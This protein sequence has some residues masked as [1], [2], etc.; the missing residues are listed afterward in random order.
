MPKR[1]QGNIISDTPPTGLSGVWSLREAYDFT[2]AGDWATLPLTG[3]IAVIFS[4]SSASD[5]IQYQQMASSGDT[6][7]FGSLVPTGLNGSGNSSMSSSTYALQT[8][9][10][11]SANRTDV[12][13]V[14]ISTKGNTQDWGDLNRDS[15]L[16][17]CASN[18]TRGIMFGNAGGGG[19]SYI[20]YISVSSQGNASDF[21][22]YQDGTYYQQGMALSS[23]TRAV[24]AGGYH[25]GVG[26][27]TYATDTMEYVTIAST[28][29]GTD[30]GN[31]TVARRR[32]GASGSNT[33]GLFLA[34]ANNSNYQINTIDYITIASTGN[35]T[36]FGDL[37]Q[38]RYTSSTSNATKSVCYGGFV[39]SP[40]TEYN[41]ID[42]VTIASTGNATDYGDLQSFTRGTAASNA[43]GGL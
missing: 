8:Q 30:F 16:A 26:A 31:L 17:A 22:T 27:P 24:T 7:E 36:D 41:I 19:P 9:F 2:L 1:Y 20:T 40:N 23:T 15:W 18:N 33:R 29:N 5:S 37:T 4:Y 38:G 42:A 43:H 34:G 21:G 12:R 32:G 35:A 39:A 28:G 25:A 14:T 13:Y 11:T 6:I 10:S 3:D